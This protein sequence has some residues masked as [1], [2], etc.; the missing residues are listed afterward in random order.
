MNIIILALFTYIFNPSVDEVEQNKLIKKF[1]I[2]FV[3]KKAPIIN[4]NEDNLIK[5]YNAGKYKEYT[6]EFN[7]NINKFMY[8]KTNKI[9]YNKL[10]LYNTISFKVLNNKK[11]YIKSLCLI[12]ASLNNFDD[13]PAFIL[14]EIPEKCDN[15]N[16]ISI[17]ANNDIKIYING[18]L[19][20]SENFY[21]NNK[22]YN[23]AICKNQK[24]RY[25]KSNSLLIDKI[26]YNEYFTWKMKRGLFYSQKIPDVFFNYYNTKKIHFFYK[27]NNQLYHK[28]KLN[29]KK[30]IL[31]EVVLFDNVKKEKLIFNKKLA[32]KQSNPIYKKWYFYAGIVAI[33]GV[34]AGGIYWSQQ[35]EETNTL[36]SWE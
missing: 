2:A 21:V 29:N 19:A 4:F 35:G 32:K 16:K 31:D 11:E 34:T 30:V 1:N 22:T 25:L 6:E 7:K 9:N 28:I 33:V 23:L 26:K 36:V 27:K 17:V 10:Y 5:L 3:M 15:I 12:R 14:S 13:L 24:C 18:L 8:V 20:E